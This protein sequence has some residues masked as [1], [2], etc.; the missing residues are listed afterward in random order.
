MTYSERK[1][2]DVT[3]VWQMDV[4]GGRLVNFHNTDEITVHHV[5]G[6]V[7]LRNV[8]GL[9]IVVANVDLRRQ[10]DRYCF[11][12]CGEFPVTTIKVSE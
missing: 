5:I 11:V 10:R 6:N 3:S 2:P 12:V 7:D 4:G 1:K 9:P 8:Q